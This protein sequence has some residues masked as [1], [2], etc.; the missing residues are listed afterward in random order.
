MLSTYFETCVADMNRKRPHPT[1]EIDFEKYFFLSL[2]LL[3]EQLSEFLHINL[4]IPILLSISCYIILSV[5][6][7][8]NVTSYFMLFW[9]CDKSWE[10]CGHLFH[11]DFIS[12]VF[13]LQVKCE[14]CSIW[15]NIRYQM[16][17][18]VIKSANILKTSSQ[19]LGMK[20]FG[21]GKL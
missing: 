21:L 4:A 20:K 10:I 9:I 5:F 19:K 1:A 16:T 11:F 2:S 15:L 14:K 6:E 13:L 17:L 18:R 7:T 8:Y 12:N 3:V